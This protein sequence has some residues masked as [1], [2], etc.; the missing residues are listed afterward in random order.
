MCGR[1]NVTLNAEA[2]VDGFEFV[3]GLDM[4]LDKPRYNI[5]PSGDTVSVVRQEYDPATVQLRWPLLPHWVKESWIKFATANAKGEKRSR[6]SRIPHC[7]APGPP[8]P[9][10]GEW[11]LRMEEGR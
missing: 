7:L 10:S 8:L 11:L 4:L 2:C 1:Y 9:D 5:A 3:D 6:I